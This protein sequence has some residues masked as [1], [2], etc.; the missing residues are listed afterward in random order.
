MQTH[1][2]EESMLREYIKAP[3]NVKPGE[4]NEWRFSSQEYFQTQT[5]VDDTQTRKE[6][7]L[8]VLLSLM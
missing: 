7:L 8:K 2:L 5:S 3:Q 4:T 1:F 6:I